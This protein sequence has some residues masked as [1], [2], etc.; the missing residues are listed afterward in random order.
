MARVMRKLTHEDWQTMPTARRRV[1]TKESAVLGDLVETYLVFYVQNLERSRRFYEDRL[2]LRPLEIDDGSV[3]YDTGGVTL[4]LR[5]RAY[6]EPDPCD[7]AESTFDL[8]F[9][10]GGAAAAL[11]GTGRRVDAGNGTP[12][13]RTVFE[14]DEPDG[15]PL[16]LQKPVRKSMIE[17]RR[18]ARVR[19]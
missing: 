15:H 11:A 1:T 3:K 17:S 7:H 6:T 18:G 2:G 14:L 19:L 5:E 10:I 9:V 8:V 4:R 12:D 16:T 13:A